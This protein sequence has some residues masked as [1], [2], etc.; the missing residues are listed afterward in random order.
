MIRT[1]FSIPSLHRPVVCY[2]TFVQSVSIRRITS[3][4]T[5]TESSDTVEPTQPDAIEQWTTPRKVHHKLLGKDRHFIDYMRVR[6][7]G[8]TG[9]DGCIAFLREKFVSKGPPA[10]GNGGKGGNI[11]FQVDPQENSLKPIRTRYTGRKGANGEGKM[12]HGRNGTDLIVKVPIGT[13]IREI[14]ESKVETDEEDILYRLKKKYPDE[15]LK[16][17][18]LPKP[19]HPNNEDDNQPLFVDLSKEGDSFVVAYGGPGGFGNIHFSSTHSSPKKR[20]LGVPGQ[21][22]Y[23]ELELK[24]IADAG[25]IGL[26]NAGKSTLL[27]AISNATP[28]IAD[29]PFTTLNPYLGTLLYPDS[30]HITVADIPGLIKGAHKNVGLGHDFLRHVERSK[31]LIYVVDISKENPCSDLETLLTELELYREGLTNRPTLVVA[32]KADV[33]PIAKANLEELKRWIDEDGYRKVLEKL[34]RH[35]DIESDGKTTKWS[36]VPVS[37]KYQG[38]VQE[39]MRI[40]RGMV[41]DCKGGNN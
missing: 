30:H 7:T 41:E 17:E 2:K 13:V 36:V 26:P 34:D 5:A 32:N 39:M 37:A 20:T 16:S 9:G 33:V 10:G 18:V 11:I 29:Y 28:K 4:A 25:L 31:I 27:S 14:K 19:M 12:K 21:Q 23:L 8:G 3:Q 38:N 40:L 22:R 6:V 15:L 1:C 24:T 35:G